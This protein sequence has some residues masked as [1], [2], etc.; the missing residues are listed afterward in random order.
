MIYVDSPFFVREFTL[1][2]LN[3]LTVMANVAA[4]RIERERLAE[5]E[6]TE[7]FLASELQQAA[8]IQRQFLP[9]GAPAIKGL[10]LAGFNAS[11]RTVG[12]D[13]YDFLPYPDGSVALALG[14]VS[15][16]GMSA[17][18]LMMGFQARVQVLAEEPEDPAEL[19]ARLNRIVCTSCPS[20]R[21]ITFFFGRFDPHTGEL[22]Y[23]NAG[24]NPPILLRAGGSV[25]RLQEGGMVL[26][27]LPRAPFGSARCRFD[28]GDLVVLFSDGVSEAVN[29]AGEEFGEEKLV[30]LLRAVRSETAQGILDTV[31]RSVRE[32]SAGA[33][34]ADDITLVAARRVG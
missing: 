10:D 6:Q 33:P 14:D 20:N 17:A 19:V 18:L 15:G 28:V 4:I 2:D 34:P 24:H 9:A 16:K 32:W 8:D 31:N 22:C 26:G 5:V 13:Y 3:L 30:D 12:G 1:D 11:C 23:C 25:E 27:I 7:R 21:F 29:P